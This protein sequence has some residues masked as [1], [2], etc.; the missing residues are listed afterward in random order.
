MGVTV[1]NDNSNCVVLV[2]VGGK[3]EPPVDEG[4]REL[5]RRGYVVRRVWGHSAIDTAR[6]E[7]AGKALDDGFQELMWIDADVVFRPDDVEALRKLE[8][9]FSCGVYPKKGPREMAANFPATTREL[10]FGGVGG[11]VEATQVGMGFVHTRREVYERIIDVC[12]LPLCNEQW[13]KPYRPFFLPMVKSKEKDGRVWHQY[14][15]E[16]YA[17]CERARKAGFQIMADLRIRLWHIGS[18]RYG[19]ED[20]GRDV[21]RFANYTYAIEPRAK[22]DESDRDGGDVG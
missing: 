1:A 18:Y 13:K 6:N 16:D 11:V 14:C 21:E 9:P 20:A 17:F 5:E 7:M 19:W 3:V 12:D 2:P 22:N 10:K 15:G 8:T 4:L